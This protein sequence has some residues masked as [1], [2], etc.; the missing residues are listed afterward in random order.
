MAK[1]ASKLTNEQILNIAQK[2]F[3]LGFV[4]LP[5]VW[6]MNVLYLGEEV[7]RRSNVL[8]ERVRRYIYFSLIGSLVWGMAL[9][10]WTILYAVNYKS[11]TILGEMLAVVY[12][13][14]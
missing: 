2:Y 10:V 4:F 5:F 6:I 14:G 1:L 13:R 3:Y 8:D 11:W 9:I 7:K 12:P